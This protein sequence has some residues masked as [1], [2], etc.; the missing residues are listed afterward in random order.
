MNFILLMYLLWNLYHP[1]D[2][3]SGL[4]LLFAFNLASNVT[5]CWMERGSVLTVV[6]GFESVVFTR[7]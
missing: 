3:L 6:V 2:I 1:V 4:I 5:I 7:V